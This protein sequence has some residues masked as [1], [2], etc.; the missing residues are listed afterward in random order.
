[1][2]QQAPGPI[3]HSFTSLWEYQ[4]CG[5]PVGVGDVVTVEHIPYPENITGELSGV[6]EV[7]WYVGHHTITEEQLHATD[8][9]RVARIWEVWVTLDFHPGPGHYSARAGSGRL[10]RVDRMRP[11]DPAWSED[12]PAPAGSHDPAEPAGWLMRLEPLPPR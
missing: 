6:H 12:R 11:W 7:D 2:R 3:V 8:R 9:V 1:M 10:T 5:E 4:C